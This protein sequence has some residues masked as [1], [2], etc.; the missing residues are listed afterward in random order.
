MKAVKQYHLHKDDYSKLHFDI[1]EASPYC[2]K[3]AEHC[4]KAHQHSFYQLIWFEKAGCHYVD[5]EYIDHPANVLFFL[6]KKQI[7]Y[8]CDTSPNE[9][10][11]FHFDEV[12]LHKQDSSAENWIQY[13]LFNELGVPYVVLSEEQLVD[14]KFFTQLLQNEIQQKAY[15]YRTQIFHLFQTLLLKVERLK[16]EQHPDFVEKMDQNFMLAMNFKKA[17]ETN[18]QESLSI[19]QYS[20]QLGVSSKKLTSLSKKYLKDTPSNIIHQRKILEA[21]RLLSNQKISIKEIAYSL[22]FDQPTYFTKYFKK[23]TGLTP[24]DFIKQLP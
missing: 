22:G 17:I 24:K 8:F 11:L 7:H 6:N 14:F 12:F 5:Y 16:Q 18:I 4:Y 2:Q 9:G 21:K 20:Q 13:Q 19:D 3:N 1:N 23:H 15:N 10:Y